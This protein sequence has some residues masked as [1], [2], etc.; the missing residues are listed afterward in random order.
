MPRLLI[1]TFILLALLVPAGRTADEENPV[2]EALQALNDFIGNWK[3]AGSNAA[4]SDNWKEDSS[5]SWKFKGDD[6]WIVVT[7]KDSKDF[8]KGELRYLPDKKKYQLTVADKKENSL[9]F[10]GELKRGYLTL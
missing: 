8:A 7:F 3:G 1:A 5:W 6:A 9:V 4:R 10:E 2:K